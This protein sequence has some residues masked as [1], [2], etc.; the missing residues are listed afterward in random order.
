MR[1]YQ[2]AGTKTVARKESV[3]R[4]GQK[5]FLQ[6]AMSVNRDKTVARKDSVR[7]EG[8]K[9]FLQK[10]MSVNRDKTVARKTA[11]VERYNSPC[12]RML[13]QS[14]GQKEF[15]KEAVSVEA[16]KTQTLS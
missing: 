2:S 13:Y 15:L 9:L 3:S 8:Q 4:E 16:Q 1:L 7:L 14:R 5:L 11:S 12:C 6:T 10:A